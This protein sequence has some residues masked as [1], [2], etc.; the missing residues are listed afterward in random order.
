MR[1]RQ[2]TYFLGCTMNVQEMIDMLSKY[3]KDME[4]TTMI[5][6]GDSV[7]LKDV[8]RTEELIAVKDGMVRKLDKRGKKVVV[9]R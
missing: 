2:E 9:L 1:V 6:V 8:V 4:V 3:P 5:F 7:Y